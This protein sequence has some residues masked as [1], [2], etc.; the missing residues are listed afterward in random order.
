MQETGCARGALTASQMKKIDFNTTA[1]T[2]SR[3]QTRRAYDLK[4][5]LSLKRSDAARWES[6]RVN[7]PGFLAMH[8]RIVTAISAVSIWAG[9]TRASTILSA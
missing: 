3:S 9:A 4:L 5:L 7:T 1:K 2:N 6:Q 8:G